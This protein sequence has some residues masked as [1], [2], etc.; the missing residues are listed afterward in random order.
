[1]CAQGRQ[2]AGC[3]QC[4]ERARGTSPRRLKFRFGITPSSISAQNG[5]LRNNFPGPRTRRLPRCF[6]PCWGR[7]HSCTIYVGLLSW[8]FG[9]FMKFL[10]SESTQDRPAAYDGATPERGR[11]GPQCDRAVP[12]TGTLPSPSSLVGGLERLRGDF[13][14]RMECDHQFHANASA[15]WLARQ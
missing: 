11:G 3:P 13:A 2:A 10:A 14:A 6:S 1:M 15:S 4:P 8:E 5:S 7:L 12:A 9:N